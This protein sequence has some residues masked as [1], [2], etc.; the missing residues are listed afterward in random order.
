M[1]DGSVLWL[2]HYF[3]VINKQKYMLKQLFEIIK[4]YFKPYKMYIVW[5]VVLN[6][7]SQW[8]N[9]FSFVVLIP[10]LNILFKIDQTVYT[11]KEWTWGTLNKDTITNNRISHWR[12][13]GI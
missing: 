11:Y 1:Q 4:R 3:F 12:C 5:A 2:F 13:P 9:V 6:F 7:V 10:I 8:L